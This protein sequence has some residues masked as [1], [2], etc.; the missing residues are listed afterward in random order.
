[1]DA[2]VQI[3]SYDGEPPVNSS[4]ACVGWA[5]TV[6]LGAGWCE[7]DHSGPGYRGGHARRDAITGLDAFRAGRRSA[8]AVEGAEARI[9]MPVQ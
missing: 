3:S 7:P 6:A 8:G 9:G 1:M 4:L 2:N 5:S